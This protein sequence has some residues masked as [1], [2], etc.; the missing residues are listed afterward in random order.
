[1]ISLRNSVKCISF[2]F[3]LYNIIN[4][5][6]QKHLQTVLSDL[7][8]NLFYFLKGKNA[9]TVLFKYYIVIS[10]CEKESGIKVFRQKLRK[11]VSQMNNPEL[12]K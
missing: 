9:R 6:A 4:C 12:I 3:H 11:I 7:F 1:M 10:K 8:I 2:H 5:F